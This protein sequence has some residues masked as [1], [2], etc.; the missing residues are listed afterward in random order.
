MIDTDLLHKTK[1]LRL[2]RRLM[3]EIA[4]G[5]F[6]PGR[7]LPQQEDLARQFEV[8]RPTLRKALDVLA[9]EGRLL[10]TPQGGLVVH[11][12]S[13]SA[14]PESVDGSGSTGFNSSTGISI[15]AVWAAEPSELL[16]AFRE[17]I[18]HYARSAGLELQI[19]LSPNGHEKALEVL[20]H[21]DQ[22]PV[23][24][25]IVLPY[26]N[27]DYVRALRALM[28]RGYPLVC[29][30]RRVG[31][32]GANSV[33]VDNAAGVYQATH[34]LIEKYN[35]PAYMLPLPQEHTTNCDRYAGYRHAMAEA[36]YEK[37]IQSHTV[38][39][40]ISDSD[41]TYWPLSRNW[42][43]G[44][45]AAQKLFD[46]AAG[47][48]SVVC[49]NDFHAQ[50]LYEAARQRGLTVGRDVVVTGFDDCLLARRLSPA[51]TTVRQPMERVGFESAKLLHRLIA[52]QAKAPVHV[53]LPVELVIRESA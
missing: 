22:Y 3:E 30:D 9:S 46:L 20:T 17:G 41:P 23:R 32:G 1:A 2:T 34:Y 4:S 16:I 43:P 52:G 42:E 7:P 47:P 11:I 44:F 5:R 29:I 24:G 21:I 8:S 51:L 49:P 35:R 18:K 12:Q 6:A 31:D 15:A 38:I 50:G 37:L 33:E 39:G 25:V 19:I 14:G 45:Q 26:A 36:G 27:E 40:E 10:R 13:L 28:D 53:H 48:M